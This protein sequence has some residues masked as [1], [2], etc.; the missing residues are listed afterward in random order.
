M[1]SAGRSPLTPIRT[2]GGPMDVKAEA[3]TKSQQENR[4]R[5]FNEIIDVVP[6]KELYKMERDQAASELSEVARTLLTQGS[7][8]D[9]SLDIQEVLIQEIINDILGL[10]PLESLLARDDIADIMVCG[11]KKIFIEVG[12]KLQLTSVQFRD[13]DQL[14]NVASRIVSAVGRRVDESSPI[15]DARLKDG[16]RVAIVIPPIALD[17][18]CIT[19][20]KFK[21]DKLQLEDLVRFGSI[22]PEGARLLEII[23]QCRLNFIISGG[24][25]SGKALDVHERVRMFDGSLHRMGDI[26]VGDVLRAPDGRPANV[27]GVYPQGVREAFLFGLRDGR[28]AVCCPEHLWQVNI[29]GTTLVL[30]TSEIHA[31]LRRNVT[32]SIPVVRYGKVYHEDV[33]FIRPVQKR[34]MVCIAV[35]TDEKLYVLENGMV[36]HN[37]TLLNC[38]TRFIDPEESIITC[39]DAAELQL[40]QPNVRRWETRPANLEGAGEI[41]MAA[42]V[43]ASLRHR[44]ERIIIG[45][46]R[47]PECFDLLQAM[48]TGH[49][50]SAGTVHA[51]SPREAIARLE[52]LVAMGGFNLPSAQ[53]REQIVNSVD[54]IVQASRLRDGSRKITYIT[55]VTGMEGDKATLQDLMKLETLGEGVDGKLETRHV[56]TGVRPSFYE[57]A[58]YYN[59]DGELMK[60]ISKK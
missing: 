43:K 38:M 22:T 26:K 56:M 40:Q 31:Y 16:S 41:P 12:G 49:D 30:N 2:F 59:L 42:L 27:T 58:R 25:G 53:V 55:E 23:A 32:V 45:E 20:R 33:S 19:I 29:N 35:D 4:N 10:G 7:Y 5:L 37:T 52:S 54:I 28:S 51:N 15:C 24:T 50:G 1:A 46:V 34:E 18:T 6:L 17:G 14:R 9:M 57:K 48:N 13:E 36:T 39:E 8:S 11:P 3:A 44:P 21:K 60:I 47:G